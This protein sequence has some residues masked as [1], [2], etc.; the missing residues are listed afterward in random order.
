[1][2]VN[3]IT[4]GI[5]NTIL[6]ALAADTLVDAHGNIAVG[7]T[8]LTADTEGNYSTAIGYG[9]LQAQNFT[10]NTTTHNVAVGYACW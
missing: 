8:A 3:D 1:M 6:G 10:T 9:T 5:Q 4:T 7:Y 2:L